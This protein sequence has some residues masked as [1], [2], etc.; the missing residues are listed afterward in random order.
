MRRS[1]S[2]LI[3][4]V[5]AFLAVAVV[6]VAYLHRSGVIRVPASVPSDVR[7]LTPVVNQPISAQSAAI[8]SSVA[9]LIREDLLSSAEVVEQRLGLI[10]G[11]DTS[12]IVDGEHATRKAWRSSQFSALQGV[13]FEFLD[14]PARLSPQMQAKKALNHTGQLQAEVGACLEAAAFRQALPD[15]PHWDSVCDWRPH[16]K[17]QGAFQCFERRLPDGARWTLALKL[18]NARKCVAELTAVYEGPKPD[19]AASV[20]DASRATTAASP[21]TTVRGYAYGF[22]TLRSTNIPEANIEDL[23]CQVTIDAGLLRRLLLPNPADGATAYR[24]HDV[25]AKL[26]PEGEPPIFIDAE[27]VARQGTTYYQ[28][29]TRRMDAAFVVLRCPR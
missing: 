11:R 14:L 27:G 24:A 21:V 23:G 13:E 5:T 28:T 2:R 29:D 20:R 9:A 19:L 4:L 15:V 26:Y 10:G 22:L 8:A 25:R 7:R 18:D 12:P 6:A 17:P 16:G 3:V 1:H